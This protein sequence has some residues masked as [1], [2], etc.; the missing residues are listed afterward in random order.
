MKRKIFLFALPITLAIALGC[1]TV[2]PEGQFYVRTAKEE[3]IVV[4][5]QAN[6]TEHFIRR[7]SFES[8]AQ[9]FGFIVPTPTVPQ[10]RVTKPSVFEEF[11]PWNRLTKGRV[12]LEVMKEV[13]LGDYDA[14]VLKASDPK[15]LNSWLAKH[16]FQR[17][18]R[19]DR[20]AASYIE[21]GWVFTAFKVVRL[22]RAGYELDPLQ[23]SF[24]TNLPF[25]PYHEPEGSGAKNRS[26]ALHFVSRTAPV[27]ALGGNLWVVA[28]EP[29]DTF[30]NQNRV[31]VALGLPA[32]TLE[33]FKKWN[34]V[35]QT[36][37][38]DGRYDLLFGKSRRR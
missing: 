17:D 3:A 37:P 11:I 23:M 5:D 14:T 38:R 15:A 2:G 22:A 21:K 7:A 1:I 30:R 13:K 25:Y 33:G 16:G 20:W 27:A 35:D 10:L 32:K 34:F 36:N 31:E 29:P 19:F 4:W 8:N 26:L 9:D 18:R 6:Q 12:G 28:P 24:K